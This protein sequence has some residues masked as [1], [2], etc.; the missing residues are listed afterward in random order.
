MPAAFEKVPTRGEARGQALAVGVPLAAWLRK[1]TVANDVAKPLDT[2]EIYGQFG[3]SAAR[4]PTA[5]NV[6]RS[7]GQRTF[8]LR[9]RRSAVRICPGAP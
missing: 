3:T 6:G 8:E 4:K 7:G 9:T 5:R 2:D 1:V